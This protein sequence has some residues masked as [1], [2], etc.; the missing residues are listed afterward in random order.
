MYIFASI[1]NISFRN[2]RPKVAIVL[3]I[4]IRPS[5]TRLGGKT[6]MFISILFVYVLCSGIVVAFGNVQFEIYYY[7]HNQQ[8]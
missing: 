5:C 1:L 6:E 7:P 3:C 4:Y 2:N 8:S